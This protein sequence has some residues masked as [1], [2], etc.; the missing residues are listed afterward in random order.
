MNASHGRIRQVLCEISH[1]LQQRNVYYSSIQVWIITIVGITFVS[2]LSILSQFGEYNLILQSRAHA[3]HFGYIVL[4]PDSYDYWECT[5]WHARFRCA[6][7]FWYWCLHFLVCLG[8]HSSNYAP[9]FGMDV[10]AT[11]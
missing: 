8:S 4:L 10:S 9:V 1:L 2:G 5:V 7:L 6:R 3:S 11:L